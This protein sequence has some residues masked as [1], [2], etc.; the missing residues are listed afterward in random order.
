MIYINCVMYIFVSFRRRCGGVGYISTSC[1]RTTW[2]NHTHHKCITFFQFMMGSFHSRHKGDKDFVVSWVTPVS[3]TVISSLPHQVP[4]RWLNLLI[5]RQLR[6]PKLVFNSLATLRSGFNVK[7]SV[8]NLVLMTGI[9]RS[10][11]YNTIRRIPWYFTDDTSTLVQVMAW[12][13]QA[14]SH[15]LNQCWARSMVS[16][17]HNELKSPR[18]GHINSSWHWQ[19]PPATG[20][21]Y[22]WVVRKPRVKASVGSIYETRGPNQ[23]KDVIL[24]V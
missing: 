4:V 13:C 20:L 2:I 23:Y 21:P 24:P 11:H 7:N 1:H 6:E 17:G 18:R 16:L 19:I 8:F 3:G 10:S 22:C 5:R 14:P 15:Y 9:F 12:C